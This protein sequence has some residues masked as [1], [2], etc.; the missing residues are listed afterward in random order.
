MYFPNLGKT[1]VPQVS[2]CYIPLDIVA[3]VFKMKCFPS[4]NFLAVSEL[5]MRKGHAIT[6]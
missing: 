6:F 2:D 1:R 3:C 4:M 5:L